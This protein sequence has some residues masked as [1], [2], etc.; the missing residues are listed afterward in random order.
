M[1]NVFFQLLVAIIRSINEHCVSFFKDSKV[2]FSVF[3]VFQHE[4]DSAAEERKEPRWQKVLT[5]TY[6]SDPRPTC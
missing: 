4:A 5:E 1:E 3:S 6:G 2:G